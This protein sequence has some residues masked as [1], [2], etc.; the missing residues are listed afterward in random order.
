MATCVITIDGPELKKVVVE[1]LNRQGW[2]LKPEA[3]E[4]Q[5]SDADVLA[6]VFADSADR[7]KPISWSP[8]PFPVPGFD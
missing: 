8:P 3:V 6:K 2:E 1:Y 4:F 7:K 5:G